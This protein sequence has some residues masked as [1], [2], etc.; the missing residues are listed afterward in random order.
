MHT[1]E[2]RKPSKSLG[3]PPALI[4]TQS[5]ATYA[6]EFS[7]CDFDAFRN[8]AKRYIFEGRDRSDICAYN[9]GVKSCFHSV[10][11]VSLNYF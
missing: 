4:T 1:S 7:A 8:L 3:D 6:Q 9:S 2:L 10:V 5:I 11:N